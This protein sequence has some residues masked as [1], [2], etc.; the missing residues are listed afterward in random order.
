MYIRIYT[1]KGAQQVRQLLDGWK[2]LEDKGLFLAQLGL[3]QQR[4]RHLRE[5]S[6]A[7]CPLCVCMFVCVYVCVCESVCVC[8]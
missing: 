7:S 6:V 5:A 1:C 8:V 4:V 2:A 3:L